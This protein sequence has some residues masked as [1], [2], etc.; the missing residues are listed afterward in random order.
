MVCCIYFS[1]FREE[2]QG[3]V[4]EGVSSRAG[5][6]DGE[7]RRGSRRPRSKGNEEGTRWRLPAN[8][9]P[10]SDAENDALAMLHITCPIIPVYCCCPDIQTTL[11]IIIKLEGERSCYKKNNVS[12]RWSN[13]VL[14]ESVC[15]LANTAWYTWFIC[16]LSPRRLQKV[17]LK[18]YGTNLEGFIARSACKFK[19]TK[20]SRPTESIRFRG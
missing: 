12:T 14:R 16:S 15:L 2:R 3:D 17:K 7:N 19:I 4:D 13:H 11:R 9:R 18:A 5:S 6:E 8:K 1:G 10:G 20:C